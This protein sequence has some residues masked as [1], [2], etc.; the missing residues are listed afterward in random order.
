MPSK[1][2]YLDST[3]ETVLR[4]GDIILMTQL[5]NGRRIIM[6][7]ES[8]LV[9]EAASQHLVLGFRVKK[10]KDGIQGNSRTVRDP[11]EPIQRPSGL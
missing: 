10:L 1:F 8:P 11:Y 2:I 4:V 3:F 6:K 5:F 9:A 7:P